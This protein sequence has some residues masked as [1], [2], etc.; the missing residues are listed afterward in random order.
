MRSHPY[1][2]SLSAS[3]IRLGLDRIALFLESLDS[4]HLK[5]PVIHVAGT[6]GK[7][8]VTSVCEQ[9][10]VEAG[11]KVG[12]TTSPH[13]Q[14]VNER[15]RVDG[16]PITDDQFDKLVKE[17]GDRVKAWG[18][19]NAIEGEP[20]TYFEAMVAIAFLHFARSEVDVAVIEVGLGGRLDATNVLNAEVSAVTSIALDHCDRLGS[21]VGSI[22]AEKAGIIATNSDVVLGP[23]CR[24]SLQVVRLCAV[25]RHAN[26]HEAGVDYSM[27]S[28]TRGLSYR[29]LGAAFEGLNLGLEGEHQSY[30]AG[31]A[32]S[33]VLAMGRRHRALSVS[34]PAF[35]AGVRNVSHPGRLEWVEDSV[36]IDGAHNVESATALA[37]YIKQLDTSSGCTLLL[38]ASSD[39][40][41][42]SIATTLAPYVDSV[43]TT[44]C[45]HP[46]A[47]EPGDVASQLVDLRLPVI[48]AGRVE[49]A[50]SVAKSRGGIVVVAGSL[51][52]AGAVRELCGRC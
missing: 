8:S 15:I 1:L 51:F 44:R 25:D 2:R 43:V 24:E 33:A 16:K 3:G 11:I 40:N 42:R 21:D 17:V 28:D 27:T 7:G 4:P 49:E 41:V 32:I 18:R 12:A 34:E 26:L 9:I 50:L 37:N 35:R 14:H 29:G 39:K 52:L 30:N 23:L 45:S 10:Y 6:N 31:V 46:R 38:G 13:L 36:L 19:E 22:A 20:L 48:P 47:M 5:Y